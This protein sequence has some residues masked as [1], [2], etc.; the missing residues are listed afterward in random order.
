MLHRI[1]IYMIL[2]NKI[3]K[4]EPINIWQVTSHEL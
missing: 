3:R 2:Q 1:D 4:I